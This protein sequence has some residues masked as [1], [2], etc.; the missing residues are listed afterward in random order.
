MATYADRF[1]KSLAARAAPRGIPEEECGSVIAD[2]EEAAGKPLDE[3]SEREIVRIEQR[4]G[5]IFFEYLGGK[6]RR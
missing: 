5:A 4:L 2:I 1:R 6:K 3:M